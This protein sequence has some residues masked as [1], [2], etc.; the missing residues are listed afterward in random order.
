[1]KFKIGL[2]EYPW[3]SMRSPEE[4]R[5]DEDRERH[6]GGYCEGAPYCQECQ[7]EREEA[8]AA[9]EQKTDAIVEGITSVFES[10]FRPRER[11]G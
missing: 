9:N 3:E 8:E 11:K 4:I 5:E 10:I 7:E 1:M 2:T 6:R